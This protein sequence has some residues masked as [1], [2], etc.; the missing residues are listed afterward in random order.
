[1]NWFI[2]IFFLIAISLFAI[3]QY[4]RTKKEHH[5]EYI[6]TF[7]AEK[8]VT[9]SISE[10]LKQHHN[11]TISYKNPSQA[12]NLI[13]KEAQYLQNMNQP[14]LSARGCASIEELYNKYQNAFDD[15]T[16]KE[17]YTIDKFIL[18]LLEKIKVRNNNY[19]NYL[20][21]WLRRVS[22]AKA[23]S[24]LEAGM[25]HTLE[26]TIVMDADWFIQPRATTFIHELTHV[27]QRIVPFEFEEVYKNLGYLEYTNGIENIKGM[28]PIVALNRNNPDGL[29]ANWL[30]NENIINNEDSGN[31]NQNQNPNYSHWWIGAI[32][33]NITPSSLME[34]NNVALKLERDDD[35]VYY[36]LKQ[37][38]LMLVRFDSFNKF[39]GNN[40]NNYHPNEMS[41]KFGEWFLEY[42]LGNA[43]GEQYNCN[44]FKIYKKHLEKLINTFY[45]KS[46]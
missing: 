9:L 36:Y 26:D 30:W 43:N 7:Y 12:K 40:A 45:S 6:E 14:N 8:P 38:P 17:R 44:G 20:C 46:N 25:P 35:G 11:I 31:I 18:E 5:L 16:D 42:V 34:V 1:M 13:R 24:W 19:Y 10:Q 33:T 32:F 23:K 28:K 21:Y 37:N 27:N 39:F 22:F 3:T 15:I 2:V 29:S 4:F 41:A